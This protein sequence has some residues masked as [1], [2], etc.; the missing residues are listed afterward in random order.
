MVVVVVVGRGS[1]PLLENK[2]LENSFEH[3]SDHSHT[4]HFHSQLAFQTKYS[5]VRDYTPH[6]YDRLVNSDSDLVER[7]E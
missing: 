7:G 5:G 3:I 6:F 4:S 1:D 2:G